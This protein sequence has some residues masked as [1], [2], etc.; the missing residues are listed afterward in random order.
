MLTRERKSGVFTYLTH[1]AIRS[2]RSPKTAML[3]AS[4]QTHEHS[5][6]TA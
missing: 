4:I 3:P 1:D 6:H 5:K 2:F